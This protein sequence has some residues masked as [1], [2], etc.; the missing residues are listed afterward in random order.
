ME[1]KTTVQVSATQ[2]LELANKC[3]KIVKRR[4][5]ARRQKAIDKYRQSRWRI[6]SFLFGELTDDQIIKKLAE[7]WD[8]QWYYHYRSVVDDISSALRNMKY[9]TIVTVPIDDW[10]YMA[11][12]VESDEVGKG[13]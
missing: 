8:F 3:S 1:T 6:W 9:D 7:S 2:A 11:E 4:A 5:A 12:L 10:R 13:L